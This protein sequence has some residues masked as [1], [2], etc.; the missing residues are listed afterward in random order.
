MK[1]KILGLTLA[2]G[3]LI[4]GMTIHTVRAEEDLKMHTVDVNQKI[5]LSV[6]PHLA[7]ISG[8]YLNPETGKTEDGGTQNASIGEGMVDGVVTPSDINGGIDSVFG[9][10]K[11]GEE[12]FADCMVEKTRDGK[13]FATVRLYLM[14]YIKF[15]KENG[16][17]ID[18]RQKDGKYE[19]VKY[20]VT[21]SESKK[22][23]PS[24]N[25]F[26]FEI[27]SPNAY[28]KV[29]MFVVPMS[30]PVNYFLVI[31]STEVKDGHGDFVYE[32]PKGMSTGMIIGIAAGCVVALG[33]IIFGAVKVKKNKKNKS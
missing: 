8:S 25:D 16:P 17:F 15:D 27:P 30:R 3:M 19:R 24:Y 20:T 9:K 26:R 6:G 31:D 12:H 22:D 7:K 33:L 1:K 4:S 32:G 23:G 5:D 14:N 21:K 18:V 11:P 28:A 13:Y 29:S 2:L 10:P